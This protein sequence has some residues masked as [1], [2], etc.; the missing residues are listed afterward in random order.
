MH[1][2]NVIDE[3]DRDFGME[4]DPQDRGQVN[5]FNEQ[6]MKNAVAE[7]IPVAYVF[8]ELPTARPVQARVRS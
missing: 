1:D 6:K 2:N 8:N 7:P 3:F 4:E 5:D